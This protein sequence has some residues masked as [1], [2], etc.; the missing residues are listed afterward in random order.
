ML[1][2][3]ARSRADSPGT[4]LASALPPPAAAAAPGAAEPAAAWPPGR[5]EAPAAPA[6]NWPRGGSATVP[7]PLPN[8]AARFGGSFDDSV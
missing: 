3:R 5:V 6:V 7:V 2:R 8:A 1:T 4:A